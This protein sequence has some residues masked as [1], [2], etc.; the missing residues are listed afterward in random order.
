MGNV[1][2]GGTID[3]GLQVPNPT[4]A[5]VGA[6]TIQGNYIGM[7]GSLNLRAQLNGDNSPRDQLIINGAGPVSGVT[8]I[9]VTNLP[10][11]LGAVTTNGIPLVITKNSGPAGAFKLGHPAEAGVYE[12]YLQQVGNNWDLFSQLNTPNQ[13]S[14]PIIPFYRASVSAYTLGHINDLEYG[15]ASVADLHQRVGDLSNPR[16]RGSWGRIVTQR[17]SLGGSLF[18]E[19]NKTFGF[20]QLGQD[21]PWHRLD[22]PNGQT[23]TGA[24]LTLGG[25]QGDFYDPKRAL[26]GFSTRTN[27]MNTESA[28]IG[29]Y[30]THYSNRQ[31]YLDAVAQANYYTNHYKDVCPTCTNQSTQ[32]GFGEIISLEAGY[33]FFLF[34]QYTSWA[35]EPQ[36]QLA[37]Q[38]LGLSAFS[39]QV[40]SISSISDNL[41][42]GRFGLRLAQPALQHMSSYLP[43]ASPY[44]LHVSPYLL[45]NVYQDFVSPS[46]VT[47]AGINFNNTLAKTWF[48]V[49]AGLT[50]P[51]LYHTLSGFFDA[52]YQT[53][54][55]RREAY[56]A[57]IGLRLSV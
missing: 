27:Q 50:A 9:F 55:G 28:A 40:S 53:A 52:R 17:L 42:R 46:S 12:Y 33:P 36:A 30:W 26:F 44:L 41:C 7:S 34:A 32:R 8:S 51:L 16:D 57:L 31:A 4:A 5:N 2:N 11:S 45:A 3:A 6:L 21:L 24:M 19:K 23:H 29:L 10:G 18:D 22:F 13:P 38:H 15:F 37:Y 20:L 56:Q 14:L 54:F 1:S 47:I 39:D 43:N 48:E 35:L 49:G 25:A